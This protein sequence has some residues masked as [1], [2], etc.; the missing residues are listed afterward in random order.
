MSVCQYKL[1]R[2]NLLCIAIVVNLCQA[3]LLETQDIQNIPLMQELDTEGKFGEYCTWNEAVVCLQECAVHS[4]YIRRLWILQRQGRICSVD[5]R[6]MRMPSEYWTAMAV[7]TLVSLQSLMIRT[8][9][10][11]FFFCYAFLKTLNNPQRLSSC[12]SK[13]LDLAEA[14]TNSMLYYSHLVLFISV[15]KRHNRPY[16]YK[17]KQL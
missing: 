9:L 3:M 5:H 13:R 14:G 1:L 7:Y 4:R 8:S 17:D 6:Y 16:C 12:L 2:V 10:Y 15:Q 11:F